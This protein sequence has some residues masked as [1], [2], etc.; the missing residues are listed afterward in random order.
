MPQSRPHDA[1]FR[2]S[3]EKQFEL[4][5]LGPG[6]KRY[7]LNALDMDASHQQHVGLEA[8]QLSTCCPGEPEL[9]ISLSLLDDCAILHSRVPR[10]GDWLTKDPTL[11]TKWFLSGDMGAF[12]D[13]HI[14]A[15]GYA[16]LILSI[17]GLKLWLI[18]LG[19]ASAMPANRNGWDLS[20]MRFQVVP[21]GTSDTL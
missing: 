1:M 21:I 14:D 16:T 19:P 12:S 2:A 17:F 5:K 3:L 4:Q 18:V 15:A 9:T 10:D 13:G 20:K 8:I 11:G 6:E 7:I